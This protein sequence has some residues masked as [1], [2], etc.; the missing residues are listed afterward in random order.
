MEQEGNT[1]FDPERLPPKVNEMMDRPIVQGDVLQWMRNDQRKFEGPLFEVQEYA[2][3]RKMPIIPH[4]TAVFLDFIT[5]ILAPKQILEIGTAIGFSAGLMALASPKDCK[6]WTVDRYGMM[7][8][9]AKENFIKMGV[10]DKITLIE[11]EGGE[12]LKHICARHPDTGEAW[13][14][15]LI[16]DLTVHP[17]RHPE[18]SEG[19]A[20]DLT[21]QDDG[22]RPEFDMIFLDC[23]KSKYIEFL[24]D[25][26]TLL[27]NKGVIIID[28]I[29]QAGTIFDDPDLVRHKR[30]KIYE[31]LNA[32][33]REVNENPNLVSTTLPLG[34]GL[35]MISKR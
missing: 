10:D 19:R 8:E 15:D 33:L 18:A 27:S 34:D 30:R 14:Q 24:P 1:Q 11:G 29:F 31:G 2:R 23:A 9:R 35:L 32:L 20:Q 17:P 21:P 6:I 3:E 7:I 12:V 16:T 25:C 5:R 22:G 13:G 4:E 26:L 28:D